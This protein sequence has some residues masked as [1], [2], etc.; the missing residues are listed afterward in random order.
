ME[1]D[2]VIKLLDYLEQREQ[3][4]M[5][6]IQKL[7]KESGRLHETEISYFN[8]KLTAMCEIVEKLLED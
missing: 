8:G 6:K 5:Q 2:I 3:E 1:R 4:T 7:Y